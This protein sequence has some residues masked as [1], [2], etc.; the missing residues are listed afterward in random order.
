ME[1]LAQVPTLADDPGFGVPEIV[2]L[3]FMFVALLGGAVAAYTQFY[4]MRKENSS[5]HAAGQVKVGRVLE[6]AERLEETFD[7]MDARTERIDGRI[8]RVDTTVARLAQRVE[9]I[10]DQ[11]ATEGTA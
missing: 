8:D 5:Q 4:R 6:I 10:E 2:A 3:G 1:V 9:H 7:R 11:L